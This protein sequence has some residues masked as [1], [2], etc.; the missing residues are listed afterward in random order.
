MVQAHQEHDATHEEEQKRW[1]EAIKTDDFENPVVRL[2][3]I[4]R[5]VA[6]TQAE[7]AV[8]TFLGRIKSTLQKHA[9]INAQ[10]PLTANAPSTAFQFQMSIW[11]MIGK[12]CILPM[13]QSTRIGATWLASSRP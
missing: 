6:R 7:K 11:C 10:G 5:K 13:G 8:D 9:P 3:H 12:E 2:L 1:K 4:T